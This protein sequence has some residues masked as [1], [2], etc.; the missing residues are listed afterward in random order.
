MLLEEAP[1]EV[2]LEV[3]EGQRAAARVEAPVVEED[4]L[5]DRPQPTSG[6]AW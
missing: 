1:A 5:P 4:S 6:S 2:M 3:E